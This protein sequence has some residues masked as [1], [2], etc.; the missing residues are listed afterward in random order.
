MPFQNMG[1]AGGRMLRLCSL[2]DMG[3]NPN[4]ADCCQQKKI[5]GEKLGLDVSPGKLLFMT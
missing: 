1:P 5:N 2:I 4:V 3:L